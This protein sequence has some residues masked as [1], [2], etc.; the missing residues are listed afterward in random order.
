VGGGRLGWLWLAGPNARPR[1]E[2]N[3]NREE[4]RVGLFMEKTRSVGNWSKTVRE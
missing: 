4:Y 1:A 3:K 2:S